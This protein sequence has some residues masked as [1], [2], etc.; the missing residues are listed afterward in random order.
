MAGLSIMRRRKAWL[1]GVAYG[2]GGAG[3]A[4]RLEVPKLKE[5]YQRGVEHGRTQADTPYVRAVVEQFKR[6]RGPRTVRR[7]GGRRGARAGQGG[8]RPGGSSSGSFGFGSGLG[9]RRLGGT[10][11]PF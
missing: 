2:G 1:A 6:S 5:I 4:C 11:D 10:R 3:G 7:E 8:R 9:Q